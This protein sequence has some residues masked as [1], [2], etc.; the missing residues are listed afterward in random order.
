MNA[1]LVSVVIP[2]YN[3]GPYIREA[4][5]SVLQQSLSDLELIIVDDGSTD[6][7]L[8]QIHQV[9]DPR[10][11]VIAQSNQGAHAAINRGL[12][13]AR[14]NYLAILNSDDRYTPDR[15]ERLVPIL[16]RDPEIGLVSS[17]IRVIDA[18]GISMGIKHGYRDLEPWPLMV[19]EQ[20][21]RAGHDLRAALLTENFLA[22]TSNYIFPRTRYQEVGPFRPL[23]YTHDWDFA[24]RV[25][26][27]ADLHLEPA[28]LLDY[29]VHSSNTIRQDRAAMIFEICW[30]LAV[31]LPSHLRDLGH[32]RTPPAQ[33]TRLLHSIYTFETEPLLAVM[34]LLEL[35][36]R[37]ELASSLLEPEN[38]MRRRMLEYIQARLE[39]QTHR[40]S[41]HHMPGWHHHLL[42][43]LRDRLSLLFA[44]DRS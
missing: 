18:Q 39:H 7:T 6:D 22:T 21:F 15:L 11:Q 28:P 9:A 23:R 25:A 12:S 8:E 16:E 2:A 37:P 33:V 14:G 1:P 4:V 36:S 43:R 5:Q 42:S 32:P 38:E 10:V 26:R 24:L 30:C 27:V 13:L 31:H 19:P 44:R 20:S 3:H 40:R 35:A 29:R 41:A 17:Y 34:M